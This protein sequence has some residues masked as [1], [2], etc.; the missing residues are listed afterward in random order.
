MSQETGPH[1]GTIDP[2]IAMNNFRKAV[3]EGRRM[4][5]SL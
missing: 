1:I 5:I 3:I 4:W 2:E